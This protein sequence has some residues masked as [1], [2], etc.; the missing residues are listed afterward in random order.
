MH[1]YWKNHSFDYT[2]FVSQVMS[3]LFI[4][5]IGN[6]TPLQYSC[7]ENPMDRGAWQATVYGVAKSQTRLSDSTSLHFTSLLG[8]KAMT[9][10]DRVK[11]RDFTLPTTVH[12]VKAMAFPAVMCG[13]ESWT[14]RRLSTKELMPLNC[15]AGEDS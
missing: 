6:G 3:L 9:N 10:L 1:D 15:D 7:L 12:L 4:T 13:C 14:K 8:R 5:V 2:D 11:S